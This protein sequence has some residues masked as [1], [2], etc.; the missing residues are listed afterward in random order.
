MNRPAR[1]ASL[2]LLAVLT[3]LL[4]AVVALWWAT[5]TRAGASFLLGQAASRVEHLE[6]S[7]LDGGLA[8]GVVL[9]DLRFSQAGLE[10]DVDRLEL[11]AGLSLVPLGVTVK[12]MRADEVTVTL[13]PAPDEPPP[14]EPFRMPE[15]RMPLYVEIEDAA[16]SD[17]VIRAPGADGA[18]ETAVRRIALSGQVSE[19]IVLDDLSVE[20]EEFT[21]SV[22][23]RA[24]LLDPW[25][26]DL[27]LQGAV[28][29]DPETTQRVEAQI[30]GTLAELRAALR[31]RG[32]VDADGTASATG[33]LGDAGL[34]LGI[35][36]EGRASG[37]P[38]IEGR[39][40]SFSLRA[41][42]TPAQWQAELAAAPVWPDLPPSAVDL[43]LE[44]DTERI[45]IS[46]GRIDTL[47][48]QITLAGEALLGDPI[49]ARARL[50]LEALDFTAMYPEW[51]EQAALSGGFDASWDGRRLALD[52][53][54][55]EAPPS[56]LELSGSASLVPETERLEVALEWQSLTWPPVLESEQ[57]EPLLSSESGR[58]Q[59]SGTL[60]E[61]Q[62]EIE[63][64]LAVPGQPR[65]EV[66]LDATGSESQALIRTGEVDIERAGSLGLS[67]S[68]RYAD[69]APNADL[70]VT[71]AEFDPGVFV[72]Q[73]PGRV[74]GRFDVDL[75]SVSPL[76]ARL[77]IDELG[78][79]MRNQPLSGSG[80][81]T[82][83]DNAVERADL[84]IAL[85]ENRAVLSTPAGETWRVDVEAE[86]L[87]TL[88][89]ELAGA[90]SGHFIFDPA[91]GTANWVL[92]SPGVMLPERRLGSLES[93]GSL[94]WSGTPS[95]DAEI[96][97][98]DVDLNPWERL[99]DVVLELSGTCADHELVAFASGS[100][101]TF[102]VQLF[103]A[104][105]NCLDAPLAWDGRLQQFALAR[106]IAG[107][108]QLPEPV[109][110]AYGAD[111]L[112][113]GPGCLAG[114]DRVARF[115]LRSLEFGGGAQRAVVALDSVPVDLLLLPLNPVFQVGSPLDGQASLEF[116][117]DGLASVSGEIRAGPGA[118]QTLGAEDPLISI[119]GA[120]VLLDSPQPGGLD[121]SLSMM[122]E[123]DSR[124]VA[125][126][127]I[128]D[129]NSPEGVVLDT[130][131]RLDLPDLSAFNRLVPQL[132]E[133]GGRLEA[134]LVVQ[135]PLAA[136]AV[137][138]Q[139]RLREAF[140]VHAPLGTRIENLA[141]TAAA[142]ETG[143][144]LSGSF[145][146]GEGTA[147]LRGRLDRLDG[148]GWEATIGVEGED[149]RLFDVEWLQMTLS[150][151]LEVAVRP[152]RLRLGGRLA[153]D[154]ARLG[155]PPG[156]DERVTATDD[157]VVAGRQGSDDEDEAADLPRREIVGD[158]VLALG[159]DVRVEAA[160]LESKL[161]GELELNW[162]PP[163][164]MPVGRGSLHLRE[165]SYQAY[166]QNLEV[167]EGDIL[168]TGHPVANPRLDIV[169]VR[170]IFGDPQVERAGVQIRGPAQ[171][172]VIELFTSPP[173]S[174]EK[175]LA[176]IL[177][178]AD[179]DH[180]AGQ[181]AF[182]VGFWVLPNVFVSYGL[183]LFDTGNVLAVRWELSR[184]WGLRAT[185]GERDTGAD[186]SFIIDR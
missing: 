100:R 83:T 135:G 134:E 6:W 169:A 108:W 5:S 107:T 90:L 88:W 55:L 59:A 89:P 76:S 92:Q 75:E 110:I 33:L 93:S 8:D 72:P 183:G 141:L 82:V 182:S 151:D 10:I 35:D 136:L 86:R 12:R 51:P 61:W 81:L 145:S 85:G 18:E 15:I 13:P 70:T 185:S 158:V 115:C 29:V 14:D 11:A 48:G 21:L 173:T 152:Q 91:A 102:A 122:L 106:T 69:G 19:A 27:D 174:R 147:D 121:V 129:L 32:P 66:R 156:A 138:G 111:G 176:Y 52:D 177:T 101:A 67:G 28:Q 184:R 131:A 84:E 4:V 171:D 120:R 178:G 148:D 128:P 170:E 9:E 38:G 53:I 57:A 179:F 137:D 162:Q 119:G 44:G 105:P 56:P 43:A 186:V 149:L 80:A 62:A 65:A 150:P 157:V 125:N 104:L 132:D 117:A 64:W 160:G 161:S 87:D 20:T 46:R 45:R 34:G 139:L 22:A 114:A 41:E 167:A 96:V 123:A 3:V 39:I 143:G 103:G 99:E 113:A 42:G 127:S 118:L 60:A 98:A 1:I 49:T 74:S 94:T 144:R 79:S 95:V 175:A 154:R 2:V 71:M 58:L 24:G 17:L 25:P 116:G 168:F 155:V 78:G 68:I 166:G 7:G 142:D 130:L 165:G 47:D 172:P 180:A 31:A 109:P 140:L 112:R 181:G 63:G 146:A 30:D 77:A 133:M 164:P 97:A 26:V 16:V 36:V 40:E 124:I 126:A 153:I 23:G 54:A 73:L 37:W 159:D 50:R 163:E